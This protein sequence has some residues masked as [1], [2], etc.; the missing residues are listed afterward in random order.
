MGKVKNLDESKSADQRHSN[1]DGRN[2]RG[3]PVEQEEEN[4]HDDNDDRLFQCGDNFAHRVAYD[5][6]RIESNHVF[7]SGRNAL[8]SSTSC[9]FA[10]LSTSSALAIRERLHAHADRLVASN[11]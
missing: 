5:R 3:A 11:T 4:H 7:N 10:A 9:G 1:R 8:E 6:R 2:N